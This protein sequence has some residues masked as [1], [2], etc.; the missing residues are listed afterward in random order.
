MPTARQNAKSLERPAESKE[1]RK[2]NLHAKYLNEQKH[3]GKPQAKC[4]REPAPAGARV[5]V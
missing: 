5:G 1:G 4:Y 3:C 2:E